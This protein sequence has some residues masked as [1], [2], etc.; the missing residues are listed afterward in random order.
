MKLRRTF[1]HGTLVSLALLANSSAATLYWDG[2]TVNL[3]GV[4]NA[5][6]N[7]AANG[8]WDS[9]TVKNWDVAP[10]NSSFVAWSNSF[11]D[12]AAF[13]GTARTVTVSGTVQTGSINVATTNYIFNSG[14]I[15]FSGGNID[16][17]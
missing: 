8:T 10:S 13:A 7:P 11:A 2:G 5:A 3:P 16:V 4:G 9:G 15:S 1:F 12:T 14:T 17:T 6:S